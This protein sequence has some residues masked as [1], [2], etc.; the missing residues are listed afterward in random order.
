MNQKTLLCAAIAALCSTPALA[1]DW[2]SGFSKCADERET[3]HI[4]SAKRQV[5]FGIKDKWVVQ[6]LSGQV[7][8]TVAAFGSDP[9]PGKTKKC[10]VSKT[11][12]P[13]PAPTPAPAPAPTPA[14][15]PAPYPAPPP[16]PAP[17]PTPAPTPAPAPA[18]APA[19]DASV[20][21]AS[22]GWATQGGG[23]TGGAA[24]TSQFIYKVSSASQL[25]S[26][27]KSGGD[28]A[29]IIKVYGTID[30]AGAD[31]G[32]PFKSASDQ[33]ARNALR[34]GSNT[35]LIGLGADA[36]LV[37]ARI[38]IKD[39]ENVIVR[40]LTIVNP[41]DIAPTWD[42]NDGSSGNWNS[43]YDGLLVD[44]AKRV[45]VDHN[46]FSDT[47][48]TDDKL[49]VENGKTK[50]CHDG[51]LDVKN[52][53]DY[54]TV[55][56]NVF[57]QHDKNNL[58]GSSDNAKGDDGHLTVTFHNNRFTDVSERAPRVRF[59]RVHVYNNLNEADRSDKAYPYG[60]SIGV[61]YM[62]KIISENN[63]YEIAGAS[64]CAHVVKN[65]GSSSKSGAIVDSGSMLN[66]AA[67]DLAGG[68]S[69]STAVGWT[70][71][72]AY[73]LLKT[74]DVKAAVTVNAGVG[75]LTVR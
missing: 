51:A 17:A 6:T 53:S 45:W 33:A 54:V 31:N 7:A 74:A 35:T 63:V 66:G 69:F 12:A 3:C 10:A 47:P 36:K 19:A 62:A 27:I 37:N 2:P 58:I 29:K 4:G 39:V 60:Y 48:V 67:L 38:L 24:A 57:D 16:A 8:C 70:V 18:P 11:T 50:Q 68:C 26:V 32:G 14:P 9:Y 44:G 65:P 61:G 46:V 72:Y 30:M 15:A 64:T 56:H 13:A 42:P 34:L 20:E 1:V 43:Q 23:T 28:M 73:K 40:N 41:C 5:S 25:L 55:S 75:K 21:R 22:T 49:P 59:G 71:P 52:A